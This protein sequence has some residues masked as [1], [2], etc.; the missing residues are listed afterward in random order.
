MEE[1]RLIAAMYRG[2][3][4]IR[5]MTNWQL[6]IWAGL[7]TATGLVTIASAF[8]LNGRTEARLDSLC[9][10]FLG[11]IESVRRELTATRSE[12]VSRIDRV[13]DDQKQ[14]SM[15]LGE[16]KAGWTP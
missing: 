5:H 4:K 14:F 12:L 6:C 11:R 7:P 8:I 2:R 10:E 3:S 9:E 16:H 15:I 13:S 1:L